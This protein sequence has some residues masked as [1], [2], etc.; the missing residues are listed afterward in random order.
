MVPVETWFEDDIPLVLCP[1]D[2]AT[3]LLL[4]CVN[5]DNSWWSEIRW[6][7]STVCWQGN[8]AASEAL[9]HSS[10]LP[11]PTPLQTNSRCLLQSRPTL[12]CTRA[13]PNITAFIPT[14]LSTAASCLYVYSDLDLTHLY[15]FNMADIILMRDILHFKDQCRP[16]LWASLKHQYSHTPTSLSEELALEAP[17]KRNK[18]IGDLKDGLT[19]LG[20]GGSSSH[21]QFAGG[22]SHLL[23]INC[24]VVPCWPGLASL[25]PDVNVAKTPLHFFHLM[26]ERK[27]EIRYLDYPFNLF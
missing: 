10:C 13:R 24:P 12:R 20:L 18:S 21:S 26:K 15:S 5:V 9:L 19:L 2:A 3:L 23:N 22:S 17:L 14:S 1:V 25:S 7:L 8:T 27:C 6:L 4:H 16:S 11:L